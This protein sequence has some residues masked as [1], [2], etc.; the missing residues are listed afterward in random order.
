MAA[1]RGSEAAVEF[2]KIIDHLGVVSNDPTIVV[3]TRLQLA[4]AWRLS[5][6][7]AKAKT[8]YE[9]FLTILERCRSRY[10]DSATSEGGN[11]KTSL[12][13]RGR[14]VTSERWI[15]TVSWVFISLTCYDFGMHAFTIS[16]QALVAASIFFVW[17]VRYGNIIEEFKQ[18]GLPGWVRDVVG[19][20]KLTFALMLLIGIERVP[21]ALAS[22]VG[23]ALL[24]GCAVFTHMRVKNPLFKMLPSLTLLMLSAVIA[25]INYRLLNA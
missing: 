7:H 21:F 5:G 17:V 10:P 2:Q 1:Q 24:M 20:L 14:N 13:M 25:F 4:R 12:T 23:I 6:D 22:G 8:A 18:Y 9:N 15:T 11:T 16:L 3:A 19:I